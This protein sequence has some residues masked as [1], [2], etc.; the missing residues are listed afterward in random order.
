MHAEPLAARVTNLACTVW[1][2]ERS[3]SMQKAA[4]RA[5]NSTAVSL[6]WYYGTVELMHI[7]TSREKRIMQVTSC[8][9]V[10]IKIIIINVTAYRSS[11]F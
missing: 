3:Y 7:N 5:S 8:D 10:A 9:R 2:D 6:L 11:I 4:N 1:G